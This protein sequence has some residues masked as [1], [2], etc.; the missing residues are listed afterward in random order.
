MNITFTLITIFRNCNQVHQTCQ[1]LSILIPGATGNDSTG[2]DKLVT[3]YGA[4]DPEKDFLHKIV[5]QCLL[6][7]R[8]DLEKASFN[9]LMQRL[10]R[11]DRLINPHNL[12]ISA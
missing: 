9:S 1:G 8:S 2:Y 7:K 6:F 10:R 4:G 12:N 3:V 11:S 5:A